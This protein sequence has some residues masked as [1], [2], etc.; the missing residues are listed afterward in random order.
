MLRV[1]YYNNCESS[2]NAVRFLKKE[3]VRADYIDIVSNPPSVEVLRLVYELSGHNLKKM[4]NTSGQA[5]SAMNLKEAISAMTPEQAFEL[6]SANGK[7][8][9]RPILLASGDCCIGFDAQRWLAI[10]IKENM[11]S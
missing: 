4:F 11:I 7:L 2:R 3:L 8:I 5:Y 6:M 1:L 9:K 10:A